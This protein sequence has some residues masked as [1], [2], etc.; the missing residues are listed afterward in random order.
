MIKKVA[1]IDYG[2]NNISSFEKAFNKINIQTEIVKNS[3]DLKNFN[4]LV[5]PGVGSF[6]WGVKNLKKQGLFDEIRYLSKKGHYVLGICLGMQLLFEQ[7]EES[8]N[9]IIGLSLLEGKTKQLKK[10]NNRSI[11]I[12][13]VGW[14][15][16][17]IKKKDKILE[18]VQ[19]DANFYF[20]HS[21][22]VEPK[23]ANIVS[24][25]CKHGIEFP[26]VIEANNIIGIQF[27]PEKCQINGLKILEKF[28]N[29]KN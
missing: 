10:D 8:E 26:S 24:A 15:S 22:Y 21:Y 27:H 14:N 20:I 25:T 11:K 13:H 5:L 1:L 4:H 17:N 28:L 6:D 2:I 3:D 23:D 18:Y 19:N 12:P 9:N 29:L 16:L 7:S